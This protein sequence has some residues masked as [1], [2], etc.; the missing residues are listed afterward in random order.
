MAR[1]NILIFMTDQQRA[2]LRASRGFAL[3]TMPFLDSW[4]RGGVDFGK[5]YTPN[6]VC[7]AAR[8]SLFTGRYP[9]CHL[10]R[11]NQNVEDILYTR[12]ILDVMKECGYVTALCGKNHTYRR[13]LVDFDYASPTGHLGLKEERCT[14]QGER[15]LSRALDEESHFIDL[16]RPAPG[17]AEAQHPWRNVSDALSFIDRVKG[18]PFFLWVSLAE[19]H[20][21]YQ[22]PEPYFDMFPP[23]KLPPVATSEKDLEAKGYKYRFVADTWDKVLGKDHGDRLL[24][25]RS[26]YYGMLRLIDDQF[27]RLIEGLEERG[28]SRTT[29]VIYLSDHGDFAGEYGLMRKGPE[30]PEVLTRVPMVWRGPG[31]E[32]RPADESHFVNIV[33]IF[34][35]LCDMIGA[36]VPFGVQGKSLAPLLRGRDIPEREFTSTYSESGYGGLYFDDGDGLTPQEEGA[37]SGGWKTFD[38]LDTWTQCGTVRMARMGD[39]KIQVDM[40]GSGYLYNLASD[41]CEVHNLWDDPACLSAKAMMLE[42]LVSLM[43]RASDP[44]PPPRRRYRYKRNPRGYWFEPFHVP[45]DTGIVKTDVKRFE[46]GDLC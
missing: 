42:E 24:R 30:L 2:D 36:D 15:E 44:L 31:I 22:V 3:D 12:D 11:S 39:W 7:L 34:P 18:S 38:C 26:N 45:G 32:A 8:C 25:Q 43:L 28:L 20:N 16:T 1:P 40:L 21:P 14:S 10:V 41:P 4:S 46:P 6:P 37:C 29:I 27:K 9:S 5:A 33:D 23:E 35:T 19:P 13:P 17:G